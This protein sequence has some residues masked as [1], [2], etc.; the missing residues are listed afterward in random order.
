MNFVSWF[1][2]L[3]WVFCRCRSN[4]PFLPSAGCLPRST[5]TSIWSI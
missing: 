4:T 3:E 5:E 1:C 2:H